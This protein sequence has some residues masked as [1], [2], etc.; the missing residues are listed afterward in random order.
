MSVSNESKVVA[1][2][3]RDV[4]GG[5]PK[6]ICYWNKNNSKYVDILSSQNTPDEGITSYSTVSLS[7]HGQGITSG[8][9]PLNV[10]ILGACANEIECFPNIIA[11]CAFTLMNGQQKLYPGALVKN[12]ISYH[13]PD[14]NMKH[15]LF[16]TPFLWDNEPETIDFEDKYVTWLQAIPISD[17][18]YNYALKH[19]P[20]E[21]VSIFE[22]KQIDI[23]DINRSSAV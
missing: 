17:S 21:L 13:L 14:V 8:N 3:I 22:E 10:E 7:E 12:V 11:F 23:F 19:S 9:K 4:F 15:I 5:N 20:D 18:E 16:I 6:V 2:T 1:R